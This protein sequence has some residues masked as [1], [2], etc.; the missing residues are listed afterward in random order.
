MSDP[1]SVIASVISLLDI[2]TRCAT[3]V[4]R[5][6]QAFRHAPEELLSLSNEVNDLKVVL[7]EVERTCQSF[8]HSNILPYTQTI[9]ALDTQLDRASR[10]L[11]ELESLIASLYIMSSSGRAKVDKV[12]WLSKRTTAK[13]MQEDWKGIRESIH[14]LLNV[15]T[16]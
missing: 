13:N 2:G 16:A 11:I 8:Q 7:S 6:L 3:Q 15:S 5:L 14:A 12:A 10:K 1:L 4:Q 9:A